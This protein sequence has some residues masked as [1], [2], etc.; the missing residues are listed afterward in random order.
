MLTKGGAGPA[1][2]DFQVI[3]NHL[4]R[5]AS[6]HR[7]YHFPSATSSDRQSLTEE[8][9]QKLGE[10][11]KKP[12]TESRVAVVFPR[13]VCFFRATGDAVSPSRNGGRFCTLP[14]VH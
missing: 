5:F 4:N 11:A 8:L 7:A 10:S 2:T 12:L 13:V 6:P 1:L 9:R 3:F 14:V